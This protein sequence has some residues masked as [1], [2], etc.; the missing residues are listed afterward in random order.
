MGRYVLLPYPTS[1]PT[2]L[3]HEF[4]FSNFTLTNSP[5]TAFLN[6]F[7]NFTLTNSL[8][9]LFLKHTRG[10][11][12]KHVPSKV[13]DQNKMSSKISKSSMYIQKKWEDAA[14]KMGGSYAK[15]IIV[16]T[17]AK[18]LIYKVLL[19]SYRPMN[20]TDVYKVR[21]IYALVHDYS[22]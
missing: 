3:H 19:D 8:K 5:Q 21:E 10:K 18:P 15:I 16:M 11:T 4:I 2:R 7:S 17:L 14:K 9:T 12:G 13:I 20:V 22:S 6:H 1:C